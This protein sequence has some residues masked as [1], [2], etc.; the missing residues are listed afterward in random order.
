MKRLIVIVASVYLSTGAVSAQKIQTNYGISLLNCHGEIY[1]AGSNQYGA[2]AWGTYGNQIDTFARIG[3][4]PTI[5][6][7]AS[8]A[9]HVLAYDYP[10][11]L[12]WGRNQNGQIQIDSS[13]RYQVLVPQIIDSTIKVHSLSCGYA[14][15]LILDSLGRVWGLGSNF[16]GVLGHEPPPYG[17][18]TPSLIDSLPGISQIESGSDYNL[19]LDSNRLIWAFGQNTWGQ[20]G[21]HDSIRNVYTPH[22]VPQI[23]QIVDIAAGFESSY[24][25]KSDGTVWAWGRNQ[26]GELGANVPI[27]N[28]PNPMPTQVPGISQ[29]VQVES[30][31]QFAAALL[32]DGRVMAWGNND[33]Y[34][35]GNGSKQSSPIPVLVTG[36]FGIHSIAVTSGIGF[37][38]DS[39]GQLFSWGSSAVRALASGQDTVKPIPTPVSFMPCNPLVGL[40][41][42]ETKPMPPVEIFPNPSR[43]F[44]QLRYPPGQELPQALEVRSLSGQTLLRFAPQS[45]ELN[46]QA[47]KPGSYL[48][49]L[50]W[51]HHQQAHKIMLQP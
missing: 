32:S 13:G 26:S 35:L 19:L 21:V 31:Y 27:S 25:I 12:G 29:A 16:M 50:Q 38:L 33:Y 4:I 3:Y 6:V 2:A 45:R 24:A 23:N 1:L 51:S 44:L 17:F 10:Y 49:W 48:L 41:E 37:A 5:D 46:L 15:S 18:Y 39:S 30:G 43:G 22:R 9:G 20:C 47:L 36:L 40:P 42:Q 34:Q 7:I 8:G 11:L 28:N 14:H